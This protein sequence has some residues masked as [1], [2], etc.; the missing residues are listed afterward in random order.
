MTIEGSCLFVADIAL[1][2]D[3]KVYFTDSDTGILWIYSNGELKNW[4]SEG[5]NRPNGL[6]IEDDRVLL[7]SSGSQDLKIIDKTTGTFETVT[8]EI[9]HGDGVEFTGNKGHHITS[10]WA[11]EIFLILPDYGKVSLL[12]TSNRDYSGLKIRCLL[13]ILAGFCL[14]FQKSPVVFSKSEV[15]LTVVGKWVGFCW[16]V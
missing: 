16:F 7:T 15:L 3:G 4:I 9:G 1:G 12:K 2:A 11:G 6:Y 5:L 14:V 10:N 8:T 13:T